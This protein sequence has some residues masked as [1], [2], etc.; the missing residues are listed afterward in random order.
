MHRFP[1]RFLLLF[2]ALQWTGANTDRSSIKSYEIRNN[3][4]KFDASFVNASTWGSLCRVS[5]YA[6]I[7]RRRDSVE[8]RWHTCFIDFRANRTFLMCWL[9]SHSKWGIFFL[10][11][12]RSQIISESDERFFLLFRESGFHG[13]VIISHFDAITFCSMAKKVAIIQIDDTTMVL[14]T[15]CARKPLRIVVVC[16]RNELADMSDAILQGS[17]PLIAFE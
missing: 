3:N 2:S 8:H 6:N 11:F 16:V 17:A 15:W 9:L 10:F 14:E 5:S 4:H 13:V 7:L 1:I 12:S